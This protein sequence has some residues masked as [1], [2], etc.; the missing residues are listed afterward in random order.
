MCGSDGEVTAFVMFLRYPWISEG[1][2]CFWRDFMCE[3]IS[4]GSRGECSDETIADER[5]GRRAL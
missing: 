3:E 1:F 5:R 4:Y 2:L